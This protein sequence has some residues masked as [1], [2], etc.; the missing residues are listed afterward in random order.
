MTE[1]F[2][3][4]SDTE[5]LRAVKEEP[6]LRE[7]TES[8]ER[9]GELLSVLAPA[10]R[11]SLTLQTE[12]LEADIVKYVIVQ[13]GWFTRARATQKGARMV[14]NVSNVTHLHK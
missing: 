13:W 12:E 11:I 6:T 3:R 9:W 7:D 1:C 14:C 5:L 2:I 8:C 10:E 4:A